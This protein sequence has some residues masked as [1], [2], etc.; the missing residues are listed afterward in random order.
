M[1]RLILT[2]IAFV[3]AICINSA[4]AFREAMKVMQADGT[5]ITIEQFGDEYHHWTTTSDGVM[6]VNT[7][8]GYYVAD[9]DDKGR[10]TAS[11]V[12][13]HE[14]SLRTATE[15]A[16]VSR[17]LSRHGLF[18]ERGHAVR[19]AMSI[20]ESGRYLPH[21]GSPRILT[22][23][24]AYQDLAFTVNEP[25][26]AFNQ[27]LNGDEMT[28]LGNHNTIQNCS[29]R[30][31]FETCSKGQFS[32]QFDLIG[33]VT[34]PQDMAH[35]GGTNSAGSDDNFSGL[36]KD[37]IE[38]VTAQKLV[39]D[40]TPYD[41]DGDGRVELVCII[42]AGYGQNQG[43]G[44]NTVWAKASRQNLNVN[45]DT[46]ISFFNCSC[47]LFNPAKG[48]TSTGQEYDYSDYI[49]GT[50]VFIHEFSHCMGLPDLYA[51]RASGIVNNQGMESW[52][53]MDYGLYTNNGFA[54][55]PYTAW[56]QEVMGWT[57]LE[58]LS[59]NTHQPS[60]ITGMLPLIEDGGKALKIVNDNNPRNYIVLENMQQ[61]G[62]NSKARGHGLL[63]YQVNYPNDAVN[64]TDSPNNIPGMPAVAVVPAGGLLINKSLAGNEKEYTSA[65]W[66]AS[67]AS[68][69]FPGKNNIT[70]LS[71]D[72]TL[73]NYVFHDSSSSDATRAIGLALR[74]ITENEDGTVSFYLCGNKDIAPV[75]TEETI[76]FNDLGEEDLTDQ[77]VDN[78]YYNLGGEDSGYDSDSQCVVIGQ[79]SDMSQI[80][81]LDPG[82]E[83]IVSKFTGIIVKVGK[84]SGTI[85]V[86]AQALG[87]VQLAIKVGQ[88]EPTLTSPSEQGDVVIAYDV[89]ED[90]YIYIYAVAAE[91]STDSPQANRTAADNIVR[92]FS[93]KVT[94]GG[95]ITGIKNVAITHH[96][97]PI[98]C[99]YDLQGRRVTEPSKGLYICNGKKIIR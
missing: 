72:M 59:P 36:C 7:G 5:W 91:E 79:P 2:A 98:T 52:D 96:P 18:H 39:T 26:V 68:A 56:E 37:A 73:P 8:K 97:S 84:G 66:S 81:N 90:T 69:P 86:N 57:E 71:D 49:N 74:D 54:P 60:P 11:N 82:S 4:P 45:D 75:D 70:E 31:Y 99:Y 63:V 58:T 3:M 50:G 42:F 14:K 22:I 24:V 6:V 55:S 23:L 94:P 62:L 27:I 47:E 64:M 28:D 21:S 32:P 88:N 1:K 51:T 13:A 15:Q 16:L 77:V 65:E 78:V 83:D 76:D 19:R 17:Q 43:G 92:V 30:H 9:I 33:P 10:I 35:Y 53:I 89:E 80:E 25:L 20:S 48:T 95:V 61:R 85:T 38:E 29:V 93:I 44:N 67:M 40:W 34:L 12:L 87:D 41:N 46:T